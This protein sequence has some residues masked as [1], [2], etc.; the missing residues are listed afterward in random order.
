MKKIIALALLLLTLNAHAD[1]QMFQEMEDGTWYTD[2]AT[3][4]GDKQVRLIGEDA[5]KPM[6]LTGTTDFMQT[7]SASR[8]GQWI[9]AGGEDS[10]LRVWETK[11]GTATVTFAKP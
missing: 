9:A 3:R 7:A 4:A 6:A 2:P 10:V 8:D 1:W 5:S 11:G